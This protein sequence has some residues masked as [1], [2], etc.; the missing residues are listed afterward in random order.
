MNSTST[1]KEPILKVEGLHL[2]FNVQMHSQNWRDAFIKAVQN[3]ASL[4]NSE[5][6]RLPVAENISFDINEGERV[7]I[8][9][10]NG[11]GKTSLLRCIAGMYRPSKGSI[12][13]QGP[14]R[15]IFSTQVGMQPELTGRENAELL[16]H[17]MFPDENDHKEIVRESLEFSELGRFVDTPFRLYSNGMQAR[18]SLSLIS[19]RPARLLILDEVFDGADRF[20]K[21]KIAKRVL[22]T[23]KKSGAVLF[24]SHSNEQIL[25]VCN[26]VL[27]LNRG[28]I[29]FDGD[30]K[31]ALSFYE[32]KGARA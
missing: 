15:A 14:V 31:E 18:L 26:R 27:V 9:G 12:F 3:P 2:L 10:I 28:H 17:F 25:E 32:E 8:L 23:M 6:D 19:A 5:P 7:G 24:V 22:D 21:E 20:F 16:A 13:A 4:F 11:A 30:P 29:E 1:F